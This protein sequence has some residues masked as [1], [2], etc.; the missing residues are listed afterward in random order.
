MRPARDIL[1]SDLILTDGAMGTYYAQQNANSPDSC[2]RANLTH[3]ERI[4]NIHREYLAAGARLLRTNTFAAA[5]VGSDDPDQLRS[6]IRAGYNLAAECAGDLAYVAADFGP[7]YNLDTQESLSVNQII[8]DEFLS[9]SAELFIFETFADPA[10]FLPLCSLIRER[11]P[12]ALVIAS[13]TLSSD[14]YTRKGLPLAELSRVME[15]SPLIDLWGLNCGIGP[16]HLASQVRHLQA[17]GKP[18][19]LMPNSGYP[20]WENQRLVFGSSPDYFAQASLDLAGAR[21]RL[22]GGCCG[23]TPQHIRALGRLLG[24]N[25]VRPAVVPVE[26]P[27]VH[28]GKIRREQDSFTVRLA[29][30]DFVLVC[31]YD[32]PRT[33]Q[34]EPTINAVRQLQQAGVDALT[35]ADSPLAKVRMDPVSCAA[36]IHRET[37]LPVL[38]HLC[39][40][41]RNV[42]AL[43]SS[44]LAAHSEGIRRVL[45]ITGDAIP[46]SDRGF[47]KPVFNLNSL[48][49]LQLIQ[50]MN[51]EFFA[52]DPLSAAAALDPGV[53]NP[54]A[55]LARVLRKQELGASLILTQPVYDDTGL[56]LIRRVRAAG[57]PVLVGL[58]PLVSY[59]NA[60]F[61]SQE[62]PGIR[63]PAAILERFRPDQAPAEAIA[64][65]IAIANEIAALYRQDADGFFLITP[66]GRTDI[67]I[68]L[69]E[70]LR[71]SNLLEPALPKDP[72]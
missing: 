1:T 27:A 51:Q 38:P 54:G 13:F 18:L 44:L 20:R 63:M 69:I 29:R 58:M 2:E 70:S 26:T 35:L 5:Q 62:V 7:A 17:Q 42:N 61:L 59:R 39:C 53:P 3:P 66:F 57:L 21:T 67:M 52:D 22:L 24:Q 47:V 28:P 32:P 14:G 23:T 34:V 55:E 30:R 9:L 36:R 8:L 31:E 4:R 60:R 46:E 25:P 56:D 64:A 12:Q 19:S 15:E 48:G 43:R 72:K 65:G 40:R 49:L 11:A 68:R 16:T 37:G 41:D 33:S 10:E 71:R 45:A 50:Q 6:I